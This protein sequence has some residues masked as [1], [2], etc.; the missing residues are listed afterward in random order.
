MVNDLLRQHIFQAAERSDVHEAVHDVY[1]DLAVKVEVRKPRCDQSGRCCDFDAFEHRLY[2]TTIELAAFLRDLEL[3]QSTPDT[4][5][6]S[7]AARDRSRPTD[8]PSSEPGLERLHLSHHGLVAPAT[9]DEPAAGRAA[10]DLVSP[11]GAGSTV[12]GASVD[13]ASLASNGVEGGGASDSAGGAGASRSVGMALT[14]LSPEDRPI[15]IGGCPFQVARLCGV[16]PIRPFGCRIFFCDPTASDWQQT[17][18]EAFHRRLK[19]LHTTLRVP[20]HYVEW[21]TALDAMGLLS[22]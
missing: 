20:Y 14:V 3:G 8:M 16:H 22:R 2:V 13:G 6:S 21:R 9:P 7:S 18:Y 12:A 19:D 1:R 10:S 4:P 17:H 5:G 11:G 15:L